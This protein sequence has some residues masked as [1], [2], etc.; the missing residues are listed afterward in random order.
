[1]VYPPKNL[2]GESSTAFH[3]A[4]GTQADKTLDALGVLDSLFNDMPIR[5]KNFN[6]AK[7][8]YINNIN[9]SY[10]SFRERAGYVERDMFLGYGHDPNKEMSESI[11]KVTSTD[12]YD[13][14][15]G[16]VK[17]APRTIII[18]GKVDK[19]QMEA[20]SKYGDVVLLTKKDIIKQ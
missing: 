6:T 10:P 3:A 14:Y 17:Q 5:E 15:T 12:I 20:L 18:V 7:Q 11:E 1:M 8:G 19:T 9:N 2:H 4:M 13:Y 16:N